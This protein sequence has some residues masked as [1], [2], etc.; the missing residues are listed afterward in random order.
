MPLCPL[1]Q[2]DQHTLYFPTRVQQI[3]K[4]QKRGPLVH[5]LPPK[6][7]GTVVYKRKK[8]AHSN[9]EKKPLDRLSGP[10]QPAARLA[11]QPEIFGFGP[12]EQFSLSAFEK[13]ATSFQKQYFQ[14]VKGSSDCQNESMDGSDWEPSVDTVEGEYWRIVEQAPD[15]VEVFG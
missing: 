7:N 2:K 15:Y 3:H 9:S 12:G 5:D 14:R 13:F 11:E 10:P 1:R 4:L 8:N 6:T